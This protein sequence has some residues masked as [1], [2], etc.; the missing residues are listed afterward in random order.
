[1]RKPLSQPD[2]N[3][4]PIRSARHAGGLRTL[5]EGGVKGFLR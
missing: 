2:K 5:L 3:L 4:S 1:M